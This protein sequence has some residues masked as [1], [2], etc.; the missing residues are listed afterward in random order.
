MPG[1]LPVRGRLQHPAHRVGEPV[2]QG[3]PRRPGHREAFRRH[4]RLALEA[5]AAELQPQPLGHVVDARVDRPGAAELVGE[6]RGERHFDR[7]V[8][9]PEVAQGAGLGRLDRLGGQRGVAHPERREDL[10][11]DQRLPALGAHRL[12][13]D[14]LGQHVGDVRVGEGVAEARGRLDV[15]QRPDHRRL[16]EAEQADRVV[17]LARQAGALRHQVG[18]AEFARDPRVLELEVR[19]EVDHPV[20]P[21]ELALVD[22]DGKRGGEERL[23][24]RADLEQARRVDGIAAALAAATEAPGIDQL[25]AGHDADGDARHVEH[26]HATGD[27]GLEVGRQRLDLGRHRVVRPRPGRRR[28]QRQR[29]ERS[30][31]A[32]PSVTAIIPHLPLPTSDVRPRPRLD[33]PGGELRHDARLAAKIT[34][35][36]ST[37]VG[38]GALSSQKLA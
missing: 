8:H 7:A 21:A 27:I 11:G 36:T 30:A 23:G 1:D 12:R 9:R 16:V 19:V 31:S 20:V 29:G 24:R 34:V 13:H 10:R 28:E 14:A 2:V 38:A 35:I 3:D 5:A 22:G 26:L 25:V 37:I 6:D 17:G 32:A 4:D 15:T 18:D 33:P